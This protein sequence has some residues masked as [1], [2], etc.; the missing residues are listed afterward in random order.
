M[1]GE[2]FQVAKEKTN[3]V[4]VADK[5]DRKIRY[6][7]RPGKKPWR[8]ALFEDPDGVAIVLVER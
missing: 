6:A 4:Y 5:V 7:R 8:I 1:I 3:V 2:P